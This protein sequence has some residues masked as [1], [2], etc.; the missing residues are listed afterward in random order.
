MAG[1]MT[2]DVVVKRSEEIARAEWADYL[3]AF[4]QQHK[5]WIAFLEVR[6]GSRELPALSGALERVTFDDDGVT[7]VLC[8]ERK[9]EIETRIDSV[10]RVR[11]ARTADGAESALEFDSFKNEYATLRLRTPMPPE[12]VDGFSA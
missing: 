11:V 8:D 3:R 9:H 2:A 7:I 6:G 10:A 1:H 5:N 4:G 12:M